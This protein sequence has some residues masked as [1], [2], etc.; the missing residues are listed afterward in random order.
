MTDYLLLLLST[1]WFLPHWTEIGIDISDETAKVEVQ[2]GCREIV[3]AILNGLPDFFFA[4]FSDDSIHET[5]SKFQALVSRVGVRLKVSSTLAEWSSLSH[6]ELN[7]AWLCASLNSQ[8]ASADALGQGP[9]LEFPIRASV[10]K[11][12]ELHPLSAEVFRD[13]CLS[14]NTEWD[15]RIGKLLLN[16]RALVNRLWKVLVNHRLRVFWTDLRDL[17]SAKQ[18]QQLASW[19][20][21]MIRSNSKEGQ[22]VLLPSYIERAGQGDGF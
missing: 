4:D 13:V 19:Y 18:L 2:Q 7:A 21:A 5:E 9:Q 11:T 8:I 12:W 6:Q 15:I 20:R 1:D 17:L 22:P 14:S 10:I 3:G 16:P